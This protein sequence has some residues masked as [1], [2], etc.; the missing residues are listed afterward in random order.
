VIVVVL[1]IVIFIQQ[2]WNKHTLGQ[3]LR[4][5]SSKMT[6]PGTR[7]YGRLPSKIFEAELVSGCTERS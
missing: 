3:A 2:R 4:L 1:A 5:T 7:T 6:L